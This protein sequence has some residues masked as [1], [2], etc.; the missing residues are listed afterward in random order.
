[1]GVVVDLS[2]EFTKSHKLREC[3]L[4]SKLL[5]TG[6]KWRELKSIKLNGN[7]M[8]KYAMIKLN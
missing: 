1:M 6:R 7:S 2:H 8:L 3:G 4:L 5:V